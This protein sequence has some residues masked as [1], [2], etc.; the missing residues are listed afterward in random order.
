MPLAFPGPRPAVALE[1][2]CRDSNGSV[3]PQVRRRQRSPGSP[4]GRRS[5]P[6]AVDSITHPRLPVAGFDDANTPQPTA[7]RMRQFPARYANTL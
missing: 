6:P 3:T 4:C 7:V 1:A 5:G 2:G